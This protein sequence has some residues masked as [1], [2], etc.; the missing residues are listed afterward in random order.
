M[1]DAAIASQV[2]RLKTA[3]Q[4]AANRLAAAIVRQAKINA[5]TRPGPHVR[6]GRL[7]GSISVTE[8]VDLNG[9]GRYSRTMGVGVVYGRRIDLG[10]DGVDSIGRNY[11]GVHAQPPYPYFT[12]AVRFAQQIAGPAIFRQEWRKALGG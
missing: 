1:F 11:T 4:V 7:R 3:T 8:K 9:P 10:F 2:A 5:T 12:P 6:T